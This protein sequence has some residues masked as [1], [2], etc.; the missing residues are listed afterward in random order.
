MQIIREKLLLLPYYNEFI[1]FEISDFTF[2][3]HFLFVFD[4]KILFLFY[5]YMRLLF[6][7][8]YRPGL[9]V[10]G[11]GPLKM[12]HCLPHPPPL[13]HLILFQLLARMLDQWK[14]YAS[15]YAFKCEKRTFTTTF[16]VSEVHHEVYLKFVFFEQISERSWARLHNKNRIFFYRTTTLLSF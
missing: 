11:L 2:Y 16:C 12:V 7:G 10:L 5:N 8:K 1:R 13:N 15:F 6:I 3:F 9:V 14:S 4:D